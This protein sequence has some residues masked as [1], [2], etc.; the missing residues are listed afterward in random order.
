M[1]EASTLSV[2][3]AKSKAGEEEQLKQLVEERM[4]VIMRV[5]GKVSANCKELG[6]Q[7]FH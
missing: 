2:D 1:G 7:P 3:V 5:A 4:N 6:I